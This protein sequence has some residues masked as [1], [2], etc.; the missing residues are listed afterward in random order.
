MQRQAIH[1][2]LYTLSILMNFI[3]VTIYWLLLHSTVLNLHK[4]YPLRVIDIYTAHT[5]PA[6]VCLTNSLLTNTVLNRKL[7]K[8]LTYILLAFIIFNLI[9]LPL[10]GKTAYWVFDWR[11]VSNIVICVGLLLAVGFSY[12]LLCKAD[13]TVKYNSLVS[14]NYAKLK[15]LKGK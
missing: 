4:E 12:I 10:S 3:T 13:E 5:V 9:Q 11:H 2:L 15:N 6:A 14:K 1:H 7:I 8:P